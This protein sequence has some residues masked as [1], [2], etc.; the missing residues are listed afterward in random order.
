MRQTSSHDCDVVIVNYNAGRLL[1]ACV[2]SVLSEQ[3][4]HVFIV[5]NDS[6]DDSL[7]HRQPL[8][9]NVIS[10][11]ELDLAEVITPS[12]S[13]PYPPQQSAYPSAT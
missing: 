9:S 6:H 13:A 3:V 5:D 7:A 8:N 2:Q 1:T 4:R 10:R 11:Q 12:M